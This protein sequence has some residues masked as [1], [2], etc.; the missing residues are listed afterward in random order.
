MMLVMIVM[1]I[2]TNLG[3]WRTITRTLRLADPRLF[4]ALIIINMMMVMMMIRM[5]MM[6]MVTL[7]IIFD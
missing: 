7:S 3:G 2:A 4:S 6:I 1:T 5:T